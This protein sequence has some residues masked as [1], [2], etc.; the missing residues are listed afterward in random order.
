MTT[1]H[2]NYKT[3]FFFSLCTPITNYHTFVI[4]IRD[5]YLLVCV[6]FYYFKL[7]IKKNILC[8][9]LGMV[10]RKV[11]TREY[12]GRRHFTYIIDNSF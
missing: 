9:S 1:G 8:S 4:L 10:Q 5:Y 6:E 3:I 12:P 11:R 2:E 7:N